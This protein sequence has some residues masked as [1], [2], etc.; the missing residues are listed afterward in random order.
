MNRPSP[1]ILLATTA[2]AALLAVIAA[3]GLR[4]AVQAVSASGSEDSVAH[5]TALAGSTHPAAAATLDLFTAVQ[6]ADL[7]AV[8]RALRAGARVNAAA[9]G[10]GT[11][12]AGVTPLM[13][14]AAGDQAGTDARIISLLLAHGARPAA[15]DANGW[16]ALHHAAFAGNAAAADRLLARAT[17][18]PTVIALGNLTAADLARVR[19]FAPLAETLATAAANRPAPGDTALDV[20]QV[21]R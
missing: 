19:G 11:L 6:N 14:A 8:D 2:A 16:T 12:P 10:L 17:A 5:P 7:P 3:P 13:L 21:S 15:R 4:A 9:D 18:D 1:L 20:A